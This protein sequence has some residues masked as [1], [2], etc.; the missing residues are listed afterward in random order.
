MAE[1]CAGRVVHSDLQAMCGQIKSAQTAEIAKMR[2]WLQRW[3][4]R[5]HAP[6]LD[7]K[8]QRQVEELARLTGAAFEKAFM[9]AMIKNH[10]SA[11][12]DA[13]ECLNQAY[14]PDM[15]NLCAMMLCAQGDEIAQ[16]RI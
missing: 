4:G 6:Q 1:L 16:M 12:R 8:M 5:D 7:R 10:S 3:Y 13:I 2:T 9:A 14:H 11:A 15:L